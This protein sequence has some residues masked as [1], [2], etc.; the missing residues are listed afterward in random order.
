MYLFLLIKNVMILFFLNKVKKENAG[1]L[2]E[3][4]C[5]ESIEPLI[6]RNFIF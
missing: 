5:E 1:F 3:Q 6:D 4:G 2:P